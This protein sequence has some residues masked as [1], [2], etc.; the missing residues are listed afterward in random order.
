MEQC[1]DICTRKTPLGEWLKSLP[2]KNRAAYQSVTQ[3]HKAHPGACCVCGA[4]RIP[5]AWG[6]PPHSPPVPPVGEQCLSF[7]SHTCCH[8]WPTIPSRASLRGFQNL[9]HDSKIRSRDFTL[10]HAFPPPPSQLDVLISKI[11]EHKSVR[12]FPCRVRQG[13]RAS[14]AF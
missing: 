3:L 11:L 14:Q 9:S 10:F 5:A 13:C 7:Q 1:M 4:L 8:F 2:P 12:I 6:L